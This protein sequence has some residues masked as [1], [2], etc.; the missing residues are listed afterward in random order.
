MS[1]TLDKLKEETMSKNVYFV[2]T[3]EGMESMGTSPLDALTNYLAAGSGENELEWL[4]CVVSGESEINSI[5]EM[6]QAE[7]KK[8]LKTAIET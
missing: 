7:Y 4:N 1:N 3:E 2:L 6:T 5:V 8:W